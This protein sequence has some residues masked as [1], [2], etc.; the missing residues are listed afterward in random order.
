MT[1]FSFPI[2]EKLIKLSIY[3]VFKKTRSY[4]FQSD[5]N[6]VNFKFFALNGYGEIFIKGS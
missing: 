1:L 2:Y 3:Y 5:A 6:F 4:S